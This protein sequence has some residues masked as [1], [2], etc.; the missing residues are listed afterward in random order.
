MGWL[1]KVPDQVSTSYPKQR[2]TG[3]LQVMFFF[4]NVDGP[5]C[6]SLLFTTQWSLSTRFSFLGL[7]STSLLFSMRTTMWR[8]G[9]LIRNFSSQSRPRHLRKILPWTASGGDPFKTTICFLLQ[10]GVQVQ[11]WSS[12]DWSRLGSQKILLWPR[13]SM[14]GE[15]YHLLHISWVEA[16]A[17]I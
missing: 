2:W 15:F 11:F 3:Q 10:L 13:S 5:V 6:T 16:Y 4:P 8:L 1:W 14:S 7:P 12:R 9:L 17:K